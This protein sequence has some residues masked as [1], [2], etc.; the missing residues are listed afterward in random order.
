[1]RCSNCGQGG[2]YICSYRDP[3]GHP[4]SK[5]VGAEAHGE[6]LPEMRSR[7]TESKKAASLLLPAPRRPPPPRPTPASSSRPHRPKLSSSPQAG[8]RV[9]SVF[10]GR[11]E[12]WKDSHLEIVWDDPRASCLPLA[13]LNCLCPGEPSL[14]STSTHVLCPPGCGEALPALLL[15]MTAAGGPDLARA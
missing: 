15:F 13:S 14:A 4:S 3:N 12:P 8:A 9:L 11:S 5:S 7:G 6:E 2:G 10:P 1:M